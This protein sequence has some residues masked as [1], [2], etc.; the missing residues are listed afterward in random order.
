DEFADAARIH[1]A[2][3]RQVE[4]DFLLALLDEAADGAAQA[5]A[6]LAD[7]DLAFEVED[8]HVPGLTLAYVQ[9]GH[10]GKSPV[11]ICD[12]RFLICDWRLSAFSYWPSASGEEAKGQQPAASNQKSKIANQKFGHFFFVMR[13]SVPPSG[14]RS[15]VTSSMKVRM[16][17]MPRPEVFRMFSSAVGSATP[18]GS[19][20]APRSRTVMTSSASVPH[21]PT[22]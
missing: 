19:K 2:D 17:R 18:A 13:T 20:P 10:C 9:F 3:A 16:K 11:G 21:R 4:Q 6:A 15:Q 1:V 22:S 12:F 8:R 7:G 14:G 5:D